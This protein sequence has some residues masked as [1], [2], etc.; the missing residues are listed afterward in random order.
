[1]KNNLFNTINSSHQ[2]KRWNGEFISG[3]R[4]SISEHSFEV[5]MIARDVYNY[6][7]ESYEEQSYSSK[8]ETLRGVFD[9]TFNMALS[10][11]LEYSLF[12]DMPETVTG[13]V[14]YT[15]K[16]D[17]PNLSEVLD[18]VESNFYKSLGYKKPNDYVKIIVK[19][20]DIV[21]VM[22]E[23]EDE[24]KLK[25]FK[26]D[27]LNVIVSLVNTMEKRFCM[28]NDANMRYLFNLG[29]EYLITFDSDWGDLLDEI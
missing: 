18:E 29:I 2:V 24:V 26:K 16:R 4:R 3:H 20:A 28:D 22:L 6:M 21:A 12:H 23:I 13:D 15:V 5:A 7:K 19:I 25:N 17:F 10:D 27:R 8:Y 14:S 9:F 11:V 1:M